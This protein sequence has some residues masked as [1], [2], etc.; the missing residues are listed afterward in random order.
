MV[1]VVLYLYAEYGGGPTK[2]FD[3]VFFVYVVYYV[4]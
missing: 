4:V 1:V 2:M 3:G